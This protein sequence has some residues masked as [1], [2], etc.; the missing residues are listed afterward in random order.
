MNILTIII[1]AWT[2]FIT[3]NHSTIS[4]T[5]S[6]FIATNN[7]AILQNNDIKIIDLKEKIS[8]VEAIQ[9]KPIQTGTRRDKESHPT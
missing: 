6:N 5:S 4:E 1:V 3:T 8:F 2:F 9:L 7:E